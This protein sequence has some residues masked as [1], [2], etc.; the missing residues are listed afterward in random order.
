[1]VRKLGILVSVTNKVPI[2]YCFLAPRKS[3]RILPSA[4]RLEEGSVGLMNIVNADEDQCAIGK[5]VYIY[6]LL[7]II[8]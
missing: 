4:P 7:N 1:M 5:Y 3:V 8:H 2:Q 6:I